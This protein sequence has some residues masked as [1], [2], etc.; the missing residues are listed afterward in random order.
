MHNRKHS[1]WLAALVVILSLL[2]CTFPGIVSEE[3]PAPA[4]GETPLYQQVILASSDAEEIGSPPDYAITTHTPVLTGSDDARLTFFNQQAAALVQEEVALF[5]DWLETAPL[6]PLA[7]GSYLEIGY[8]QISSP[9]NLLSL[10]FTIS[11]YY[12][13]AAHPGS[14]NRTLTYDL[15]AGAFL[16]LDQ[17][18]LPGVDY[19]GPISAYCITEL[20]RRAISF[21]M[22][23]G[24]ATPTS[25]NYRNW[26]VAADGLLI[27]FDEY[28]VAPYAA[29][30]QTVLVPYTELTV[31]LD[32]DGPLDYLLP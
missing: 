12:D 2:A 6:T 20:S 13:G 4:P 19:L 17:F 26:N 30:P 23:S 8:A 7:M 24:G 25:D 21:E 1:L 16:T 15:E 5:K 31:T 11:F 18:F 29:G 14:S 22:F 28:Q 32:P 27:T 3:P 9:G 10:K